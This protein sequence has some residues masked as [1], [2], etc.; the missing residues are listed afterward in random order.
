ML[1][2]VGSALGPK[3]ATIVAFTAWVEDDRGAIRMVV[4]KAAVAK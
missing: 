4:D 2:E 3:N 1:G